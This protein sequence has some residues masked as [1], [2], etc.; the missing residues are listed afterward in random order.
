VVRGYE[1]TL[2]PL[3]KELA[4]ITIDEAILVPPYPLK[5]R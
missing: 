5:L 1:S 2:V 4:K 3:N